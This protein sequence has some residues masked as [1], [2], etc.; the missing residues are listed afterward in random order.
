MST[1]QELK[2]LKIKYLDSD[3]S[4]DRLIEGEIFYNSKSF[5][6]KAPIAVA[7]FHSGGLMNTAR[8]LFASSASC[9]QTA[10]FGAGGY[11]DGTGD[12]NATE[13]Y[14][15]AKHLYFPLTLECPKFFCCFLKHT[16]T[17]SKK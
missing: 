12:T 5:Q 17:I 13:E 10:A 2:G 4:G 15:V 6:L 3:T 11:I 14:D 16:L 7:A 9:T 1:Y 8:R